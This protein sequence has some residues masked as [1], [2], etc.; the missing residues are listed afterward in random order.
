MPVGCQLDALAGDTAHVGEDIGVQQVAVG[1]ILDLQD[2]V[3]VLHVIHGQRRIKGL[4][5]GTN[6]QVDVR[7]GLRLQIRVVGTDGQYASRR[8][9]EVLGDVTEDLLVG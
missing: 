6:T 7:G 2:A 3:V 5:L 9:T 4:T 8:G 1:G